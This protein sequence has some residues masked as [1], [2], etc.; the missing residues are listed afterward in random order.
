ML[1][2]QLRPEFT[3]SQLRGTEIEL[4]EVTSRSAE[5]ML[6]ITYPTADI[7][8][9]LRCAATDDG[10][11]VVLLGERGLGKSHTEAVLH[12]AFAEPE[13]V[14]QWARGWQGQIPG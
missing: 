2:L 8:L 13:R 10:R 9:A 12:F 5:P 3:G 4:R 7:R 1:G 6:D 11:P 14:E